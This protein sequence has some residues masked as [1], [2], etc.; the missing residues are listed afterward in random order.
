MADDQLERLMSAIKK[1]GLYDNSIIIVLSDHGETLTGH[2]TDLRV[3][4]QNHILLSF[5]L[6]GKNSHFEVNR[7]VSTTDIFPTILDLLG[8]NLDEYNYEGSSLKPLLNGDEKDEDL[9]N[10]IFLETGF[11]ID[12]PGGI[13]VSLQ[14]MIDEGI[15]FYEW[16]K[17]GIVTVKEESHQELIKRKQRAIQNTKW[18]LIFTPLVRM[19]ERNADVSLYDLTNDPECKQ[20]VSEKFPKVYEE[21]LKKLIHHYKGEI[22]EEYLSNTSKDIP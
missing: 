14:E 2:G 1:E 19:D 4:G 10:Y 15:H 5:K 13:G 16:D 11:S 18:K 3:S 9:D 20:D 12:V 21:L 22:T 17:K 7:L 6:P 8:L